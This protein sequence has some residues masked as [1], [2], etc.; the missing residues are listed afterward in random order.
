M[1]ANYKQQQKA[2]TITCCEE[3]APSIVPQKDLHA[4][5][6]ASHI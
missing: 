6:R 2:S 5:N 4:R 1:Y 3:P